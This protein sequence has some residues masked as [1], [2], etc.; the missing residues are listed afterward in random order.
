M[1]ARVRRAVLAAAA[2]VLAVAL[3]GCQGAYDVALPGGVA[4][5]GD[6][7]RV[8][9]QFADVLDLVPQSSVKVGDVTVGS[10][11]KIS[12]DGWTARVTVRLKDSVQLPDNA[13]AELK[14]TSLLGEKYV[15]LA[16]PSD[17]AAVG[18]LADGDVIPLSRSGRN[19][20][21]EEVLGAMSLLLNGGGVAQLKIIET[22]LNKALTG[23]ESSVRDLLT[24]LDTLVG[25]LDSQK[26]EINRAIDQIDRLA[27]R[28]AAQRDDLATAL[29]QLPGGLK[30][31]ADQRQ[32]LTTLLTSLDRLG[33][34]GSRVIQASKNDTVAN[35]TALK[36]V[37]KSLNDAGDDL[38]ESL[39]LLL[40]YPFPDAAVNGI[41]GDY[42]N[43][44]ITADL[45]ARSLLDVGTGPSGPLPGVP[46]LGSI[47]QLPDVKSIPCTILGQ[48]V[49]FPGAKCPAAIAPGDLTVQCRNDTI[50]ALVLPFRGV[51]CPAGW[52]KVSAQPTPA[53][54]GG[55]G[56]CLP[57]VLCLGAAEGAPGTS[58]QEYSPNLAGLL[59][60]G[61]S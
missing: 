44:W 26:G 60:G 23:N 43:L 59:M 41:K 38:P 33:D 21:V 8:T 9:V 25:S 49:Q 10:V 45:D 37:L 19:P 39:Q 13:T 7:Y 30:V 18:R 29:D 50:R 1:S 17:A 48:V 42:T 22:E 53:P 57:G 56:L 35:L 15:S 40:T 46:G 27:A 52:T 58:G 4:S 20:E 2:A 36:P 54:S 32:Q 51:S 28:L 24:K 5:R 12:L 14:Q 34:V 16:A 31:L 3:A 11:E 47:P 55:G 61:V 6:I